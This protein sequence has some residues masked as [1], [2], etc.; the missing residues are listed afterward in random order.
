[1]LNRTHIGR[2]ADHLDGVPHYCGIPHRPSAS[3]YKDEHLAGFN[4]VHWTSYW[5]PDPKCATAGCIAGHAV[6]LLMPERTATCWRIDATAAELLGLSE[7]CGHALFTVRGV[8]HDGLCWIT[9]RQASAVLRS[10]AACDAEPTSKSIADAWFRV[11]YGDPEGG[12]AD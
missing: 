2:L 11:L 6:D 3:L 7:D 9:P 8:P 5:E 12:D 10:I 4:M 1:M